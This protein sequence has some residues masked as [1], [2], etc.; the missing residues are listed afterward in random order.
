MLLIL[1]AYI[2]PLL[3][4]LVQLAVIILAKRLKLHVSTKVL[5]ILIVLMLLMALNLV[6]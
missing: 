6:G 3:M 2:M 4:V 1:L 5:N